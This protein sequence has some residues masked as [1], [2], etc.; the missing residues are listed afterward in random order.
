M[1]PSARRGPSV[2]RAALQTSTF[3]A[4]DVTTRG[5]GS[6]LVSGVAAG[7][8]EAEKERNRRVSFHVVLTDAAAQERRLP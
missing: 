8:T 6:T 7:L 4:L 2:V 1:A 5:L 3:D